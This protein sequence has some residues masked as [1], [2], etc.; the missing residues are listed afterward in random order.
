VA[1]LLSSL[2]VRHVSQP[3]NAKIEPMTPATNA[4]SVRPVNGLNQSQEN[5]SASASSPESAFAIATTVK[6]A[7]T[8]IWKPT[9][10]ICSRSVVLMP[11]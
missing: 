8:S 1:S 11:R 4:E 2:T 6:I 3:Q 10:T 9:S 5:G 7:R